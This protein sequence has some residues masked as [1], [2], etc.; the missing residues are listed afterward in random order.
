MTSGW[1]D[2]MIELKHP[3]CAVAYPDGIS[4]GG[5]QMC[6]PDST[7]VKCGCGVVAAQEVLLYLT[8]Y[9]SC[10]GQDLFGEMAGKAIVTPEEYNRVLQH[11]QTRYMHL[12]PSFGI[13]GISLVAGMNAVFRRYTFPYRGQWKIASRS[14]YP[15]MEEML[16]SD[17]P[18]IISVGPNFPVLWGKKTV[19]LHPGRT[20]RSIPS[21]GIRAHYMIATGL[22]EDSIHVSSWGRRYTIDRRE[23]DEYV[24]RISSSIVSNLVYIRNM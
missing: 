4:F 10:P 8:R 3:L 6:S 9:H 14:F 1:D 2:G 15:S 21:Q 19:A 13:N 23:Y 17:I 20:L 5:S 16:R 24:R 12:I 11:L 7:M 22:E 18:V